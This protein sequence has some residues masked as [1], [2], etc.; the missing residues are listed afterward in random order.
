[1]KFSAYRLFILFA[2]ALVLASVTSHASAADSKPKSPAPA[3]SA[4]KTA[5]APKPAPPSSA[6]V[7]RFND[8]D[9]TYRWSQ[10][11]QYEFTPAG[12]E[13][14]N[15]WTDMITLVYAP[16]AT[17][18]EGLATFAN[19]CLETYKKNGA[20]VL[21]TRSVPM[22]PERPAEH[23][24]AVVFAPPQFVEA[25]FA[26]FQLLEGN[27]VV[28]IYGHRIYGE[29]VGKAMSAWLAANGEKSENALMAFTGT[30]SQKTLNAQLPPPPEPLASPPRSAP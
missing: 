8:T 27:G 14:L 4:S 13:N 22:T 15:R 5:P 17:D 6:P 29:N 12:Q 25:T 23:F 16:N 30:P 21:N 24:V 10:G 26:R 9:F 1:M 20:M 19:A 28:T 2:S 18:G 7:L 3:K 11:N